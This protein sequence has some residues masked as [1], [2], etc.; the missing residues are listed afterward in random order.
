MGGRRADRWGKP[1]HMPSHLDALQTPGPVALRRL[2]REF[3]SVTKQASFRVALWSDFSRFW[4]DFERFWEAEMAAKTDFL[5]VTFRCFFRMRFC[6]DFWLFFG[7]SKPENS[8]KTIGFSR[9]FVDFHK[10][11]VF[12]KV[13]KNSEFWLYF[14]RPKQRKS[15]KIWC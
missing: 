14:W 1:N 3:H 7:G 2:P 8:I 11:D 6:M 13:E 15:V 10:I 9:F 4:S 12:K 5:E